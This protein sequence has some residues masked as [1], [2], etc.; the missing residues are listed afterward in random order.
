MSFRGIC[1]I[2]GG[3]PTDIEHIQFCGESVDVC[4]TCLQN[5]TGTTSKEEF[6]DVE[7]DRYYVMKTSLLEAA[8]K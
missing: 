2:H 8:G 5:Q 3:D 4:N 7:D 1:D 6:Q